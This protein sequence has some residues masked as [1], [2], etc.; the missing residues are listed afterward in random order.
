LPSSS[1][2]L[3]RRVRSVGQSSAGTVDTD[4][5]T[6]NQVAH[7]DE[8]AAPEKGVS[9]VVVA[10]RVCS[11]A[12][13]LSQFGREHD[14]HDDAVDGDD[15]AENNRDQVLGADSWRL[16]TTTED[17][18]SGNEDS[19]VFLVSA[20]VSLMS[21]SCVLLSCRWFV[22]CGSNNGQADTEADA[23]GGPGVGR[24]SLDE[25]ANLSSQCQI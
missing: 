14:A 11:V 7:A 2:N 10:S 25:R 18:G 4:T 17:R 20:F 24:N 23:C 6:A 3:Q 8:S 13:N 21:R 22:P 16:D 19:P 9:S 5:D 15:L 1:I 12:A